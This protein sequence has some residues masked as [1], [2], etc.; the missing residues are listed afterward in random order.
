MVGMNH[1]SYLSRNNDKNVSADLD[2]STK[3]CNQVQTSSQTSSAHEKAW[4]KS[5]S[6]ICTV[7]T[8]FLNLLGHMENIRILRTNL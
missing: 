6:H 1:K 7:Q 3:S 8:H 2:G 4:S 5:L